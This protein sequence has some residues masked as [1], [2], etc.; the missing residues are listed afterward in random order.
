VSAR[1]P[2]TEG[3]DLAE[4]GLITPRLVG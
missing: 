1:V 2:R 4:L 3:S